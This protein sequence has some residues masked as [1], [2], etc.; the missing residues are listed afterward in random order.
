MM[1]KHKSLFKR[2][3][4]TLCPTEETKK[5]RAYGPI[6]TISNRKAFEIQMVQAKK[7]PS[8]SFRTNGNINICYITGQEVADA[9]VTKGMQ[10]W[11]KM[12]APKVIEKGLCCCG[13]SASGY[14]DI[15]YDREPGNDTAIGM[16][17]MQQL[18]ANFKHGH[19]G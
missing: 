6:L 11:G 8:K 1:I 12:L 16:W 4:D 2:I 18:P 15:R 9:G 3:I 13:L 5:R 14:T 17:T 10:G 19:T 7:N